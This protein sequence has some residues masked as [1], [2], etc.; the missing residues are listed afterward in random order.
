[1]KRIKSLVQCSTCWKMEAP[2]Y[3]TPGCLL[4][5]SPQRSFEP[6]LNWV[7]NPVFY[8]YETG[9]GEKKKRMTVAAARPCEPALNQTLEVSKKKKMG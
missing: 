5:V 3:P 1:M 2:G 9:E 6:A 8:L 7:E 4:G